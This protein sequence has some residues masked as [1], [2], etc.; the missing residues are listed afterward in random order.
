[1]QEL[2]PVSVRMLG[3]LHRLRKEKGLQP[4]LEI[5]LA[6]SGR[7]ASDIAMDLNLPLNVIGSIYCNHIPADIY[8]M[9]HPGDRIAFVPKSVP[10]PH[11]RYQGFP[12]IKEAVMPVA[13][14]EAMITPL[15]AATSTSMA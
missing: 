2:K 13:G 4:Y 3:T 8:H 9:V 10:G 5:T 12:W 15:V 6:T 14:E 1:M 11:Q 7:K